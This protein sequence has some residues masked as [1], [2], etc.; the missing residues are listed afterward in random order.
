MTPIGKAFE[1]FPP[2]RFP[3]ILESEIVDLIGV[4]GRANFAFNKKRLGTTANLGVLIRL[5][6]FVEEF[7]ARWPGH[8]PPN[9]AKVLHEKDMADLLEAGIE[10]WGITEAADID[11]RSIGRALERFRQRKSNSRTCLLLRRSAQ[12]I[13]E[14]IGLSLPARRDLSLIYPSVFSTF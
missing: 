9:A 13:C 3:T 12:E 5:Q 7:W 10:A 4:S 14:K 8:L 6:D 2:N 11:P 1:P